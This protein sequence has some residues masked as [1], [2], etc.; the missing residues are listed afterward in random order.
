LNMQLV[1]RGLGG[2][3]FQIHSLGVNNVK[4]QI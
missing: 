3:R 2:A 4:E 1:Q